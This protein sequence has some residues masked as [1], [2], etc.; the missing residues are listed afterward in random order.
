MPHYPRIQTVLAIAA[1]MQI[2]HG[3]SSASGGSFPLLSSCFEDAERVSEVSSADAV[4]V[5]YAS[6]AGAGNGKCY[7]VSV[8]KDGRSMN[9]FLVGAALPVIQQFE[10]EMRKHV[11]EAPR[12]V[13]PVEVASVKREEPVA[14]PEPPGPRTLAGLRGW[15]IYGR[16]VDLNAMSEPN[17]VVYFW[18]ANDR[19]SMR[20]AEMMDYIYGQYRSKKLEV[21]GIATA[22]SAEQLRKACEQHEVVWPQI[23]DQ[24]AIAKQYQ[25]NAAKPYLVLD[26]ARK[27]IASVAS[28]KE[29]EI[30]LRK[31]GLK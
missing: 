23:L 2:A 15:D 9:G 10:S 1:L 31:L 16:S 13:A 21:V 4:R 19:R 11:P 3:A 29:I 27:V 22:E 24:G 20:T 28:P 7:S 26:S 8:T 12:P 17:V 5:R 18:S 30:E 14:P 25:V 6:V